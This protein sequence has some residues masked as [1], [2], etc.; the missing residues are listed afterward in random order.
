M[1][2]YFSADKNPI[3]AYFVLVSL[4]LSLSIAF[5]LLGGYR[6][7]SGRVVTVTPFML[8]LFR[9]AK[10]TYR[11]RDKGGLSIEQEEEQF[12][13]WYHAAAAVPPTLLVASFVASAF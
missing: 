10:R 3:V 9:E 8:S 11:D 7:G 5:L 12:R 2:T 1:P 13:R 4:A 6:I